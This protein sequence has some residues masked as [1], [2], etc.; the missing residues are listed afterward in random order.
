MALGKGALD[1]GVE[2]RGAVYPV[3]VK[4]RSYY[5]KSHAKAHEQVAR[6]M[7]RLGKTE[8]WHC[9]ML[10]MLSQKDKCLRTFLCSQR[11]AFP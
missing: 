8:G 7:D 5:D 2:F 9:R 6:Y 4:K 11:K 10:C 3:E 1:L